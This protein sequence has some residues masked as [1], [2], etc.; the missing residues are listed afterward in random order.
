MSKQSRLRIVFLAIILALVGSSVS[1]LAQ[2]KGDKNIR[3]KAQ[4]QIN[5]QLEVVNFSDLSF[6][7]ST[8]KDKVLPLEPITLKMELANRKMYQ[9]VG[10]FSVELSNGFTRVLVG[11]EG[12]SLS[13]VKRNLSPVLAHVIKR[14]QLISPTENYETTEVITLGL[15]QIFPTPGD[16][17]I[18]LQMSDTTG[19]QYVYSNVLKI[20]VLEPTGK[21]LEAYNYLKQDSHA[22]SFFSGIYLNRNR[23][24][25][26]Y[27]VK[28]FSSS[29]YSGYIEVDLAMDKIAKQ[30]YQEGIEQLETILKN[31][32]VPFKQTILSALVKANSKAG[33][34]KKAKEYFEILEK[35]YPYSK[36]TKNVRHYALFSNE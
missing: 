27:F 7:I 2:N 23:E 5:Q 3:A 18:Q 13:E 17:K 4:P 20:K 16:Y 6:E 28:E 1:T 29:P 11:K 35:H 36:E 19:Q 32:K 26:E 22:G 31:D 8:P 10:H 33:N 34:Q 24:Q 12:E 30:Q 15:D 25:F 14:N 21:D 9:I